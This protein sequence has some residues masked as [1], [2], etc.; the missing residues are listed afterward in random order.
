KPGPH[1]Q[2]WLHSRF[3]MVS[4]RLQASIP[5]GITAEN[6]VVSGFFA[7]IDLYEQPSVSQIN[8]ALQLM[9]ESGLAGLAGRKTET[10]SYGQLRRLL[11]ARALVH[12]PV[13]LLLD[14][15]CSG[16]DAASR[17]DF[18]NALNRAVTEGKTQVIHATHHTHDLAGSIDHV[19]CLEQGR[20]VYQGPYPPP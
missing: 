6:L 19:L 17:S 9:E 2:Q 3:G 1:N 18:L 8:A 16:L 11:L 10:L 12:Q 15:P 20:A 5:S 14:E 13:L 7:S 4:D